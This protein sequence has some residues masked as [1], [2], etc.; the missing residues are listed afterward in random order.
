MTELL[1]RCMVAHGRRPHRRAVMAFREIDG[2]LSSQ[3]VG[4]ELDAIPIEYRP[5]S[6]TSVDWLLIPCPT[7]GLLKVLRSDL[8]AALRRGDGELAIA[9]RAPAGRPGRILRRR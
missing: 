6:A 3:P 1:V 8:L 4:S 5:D 2:E 9:A 7:H